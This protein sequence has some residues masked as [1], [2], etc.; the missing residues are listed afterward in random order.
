MLKTA[1]KFLRSVVSFDPGLHDR[2]VRHWRWLFGTLLAKLVEDGLSRALWREKLSV[3]RRAKASL[4][5]RRV[6]C[7][8]DH[9]RGSLLDFSD[10]VPL[11]NPSSGRDEATD[12]LELG[13]DRLDRIVALNPELLLA[14]IDLTFQKSV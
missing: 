1:T 5:D 4:I 7:W 6:A 9:L 3:S 11:A 14:P 2:I 8:H 10:V 13:Y 12:S